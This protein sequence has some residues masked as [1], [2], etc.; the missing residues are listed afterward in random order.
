VNFPASP[1]DRVRVADTCDD[2]LLV[3]ASELLKQNPDLWFEWGKIDNRYDRSSKLE[4]AIKEA[5]SRMSQI[6]ITGIHER[7]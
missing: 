3:K 1:L 6:C 7:T 4:S 2:P 5:V